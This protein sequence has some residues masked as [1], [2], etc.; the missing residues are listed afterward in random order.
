M[1]IYS[2][3]L[4]RV[5][6]SV[7]HDHSTYLCSLDPEHSTYY[8][9]DFPLKHWT[10]LV[11]RSTVWRCSQVLSQEQ[12]RYQK[13]QAVFLQNQQVRRTHPQNTSYKCLEIAVIFSSQ[14]NLKKTWIPSVM[15]ER[16]PVNVAWFHRQMSKPAFLSDVSEISA[17]NRDE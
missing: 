11:R 8:Q 7:M 4:C 12:T 16:H 1:S 13:L 5:Q 15:N 10:T 3:T 2:R 17:K 9:R 14:T 6:D